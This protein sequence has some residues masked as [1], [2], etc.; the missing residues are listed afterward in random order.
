MS[1]YRP[2]AERKDPVVCGQMPGPSP[3]AQ[4]DKLFAEDPHGESFFIQRFQSSV[5]TTA[6]SE[7]FQ[8][9]NV[10][11]KTRASLPQSN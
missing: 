9:G 8:S 7:A 1:G 10:Q 4:D 6:S 2:E 5:C 11:S 3:A